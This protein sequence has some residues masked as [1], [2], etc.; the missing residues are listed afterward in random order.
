[1]TDARVSF[2]PFSP[3]FL[4]DPYP[5][6]AELRAAVPIEEHEFGFWALWR[7]A[8]IS[9]MLRDRLSVEE[10]NVSTFGPLRQVLESIYREAG[11]EVRG[12]ALSLSI[13]ERDPPDHTRLR[14]L[15]SQAFT[16]RTVEGLAPVIEQLV[17]QSLDRIA[18]GGTVDLIQELAFP[19]PFAV[20]SSMLG[21]PETDVARLRELSGLIARSLEPVPDEPTM[22]AIVAADVEMSARTAEA[23]AWKRVHP[24]DD[25]LTRLI[26]AR[27]GSDVLSNEELVAQVVLLYVAGHETTVNLIGNGTLAL[28]AYPDQAALWRDRPDL[29]DNAIEELLRY[30]S[31]VQ[32]S[33]RVTLVD[34]EVGDFTIPQGRFVMANLG[35]AN[36]DEAVFGPEADQLRL[37][38][39][40]AKQHLSFGGGVHHCLG[41]ALARSEGRAALSALVRRFPGLTLAAEP[42]RNSRINLRGLTALPVSVR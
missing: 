26:E 17:S 20:I 2:A 16:P 12:G 24:A 18:D 33:R 37:D 1:M 21:M 13:L 29:D 8:E 39:S 3:E 9:T 15:V 42:T 36:R 31:P 34:Y 41:A 14:R 27:D 22:R 4:A 40:N 30:D 25:L 32:S 10:S 38:R 5:H 7:H 28:L 6:Y 19:L 23:I 35:S 11:L